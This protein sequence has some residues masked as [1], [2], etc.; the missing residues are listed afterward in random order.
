MNTYD[1]CPLCENVIF[2]VCERE[3]CVQSSSNPDEYIHGGIVICCLK[4]FYHLYA[5]PEEKQ[6]IE[7]AIS[8]KKR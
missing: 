8:T 2:H 5:I 1:E 3:F 7:E 4:C 6:E